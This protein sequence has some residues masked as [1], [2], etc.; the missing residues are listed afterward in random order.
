[1]LFFISVTVSQAEIAEHVRASLSAVGIGVQLK[2]LAKELFNN[3]SVTGDFNLAFSETW[4]AP[5]DPHAYVAAF[6]V[7]NEADYMAQQGMQSP[8]T[9]QQLNDTITKVLTDTDEPSR[10][11]GWTSILTALHEQAIYLPLSYVR[12]LAV[13][14]NALEGMTYVSVIVI[15][16]R[17]ALLWLAA[18][19]NVV[20][21]SDTSASIDSR[22]Y[23]RWQE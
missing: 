18:S 22:T 8:M 11:R 19:D 21:S 23:V 4:G 10:Q 20:S 15:I 5:Y 1:M 12:N 6:R 14:N 9:Q 3:A 2:P 16:C 17:A 7:A 13:T